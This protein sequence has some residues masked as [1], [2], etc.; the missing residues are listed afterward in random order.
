[1]IFFFFFGANF[2]EKVFLI[3]K[4]LTLKIEGKMETTGMGRHDSNQ[5]LKPGTVSPH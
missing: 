5:L 3:R 4:D 2:H 1:M